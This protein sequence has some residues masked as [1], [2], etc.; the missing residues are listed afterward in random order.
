MPTRS[1]E[2]KLTIVLNKAAQPL[3]MLGRGVE[4]IAPAIVRRNCVTEARPSWRGIELRNTNSDN[5]E[6]DGQARERLRIGD[7]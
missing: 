4:H 7:T 5:D 3:Y 1:Q 6:D 2:E